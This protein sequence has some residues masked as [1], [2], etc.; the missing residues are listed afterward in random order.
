MKFAINTY[1]VVSVTDWLVTLDTGRKS[2]IKPMLIKNRSGS[3]VTANKTLAKKA[4]KFVVENG[5]L[6][7]IK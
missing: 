1:K 4:N 2:F 7:G 3:R 5:V 6:F